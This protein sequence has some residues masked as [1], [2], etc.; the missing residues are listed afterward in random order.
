[1]MYIILKIYGLELLN[2]SGK[3][4]NLLMTMMAIMFLEQNKKI[5][6]KPKGKCYNKYI[7]LR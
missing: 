2:L 7:R 6:D 4:N 5:I 1:M 3:Q